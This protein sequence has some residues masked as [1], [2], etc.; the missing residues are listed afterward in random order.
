MT[1]LRSFVPPADVHVTPEHV[2]IVMDVPGFKPGEL[3]IELVDDLLTIRGERAFPHGDAGRREWYRFERGYGRFERS[4]RMPTGLDPDLV[5]ASLEDGVLNLLIPMPE[6]RK[7]R[8]I[9][10]VGGSTQPVIEQQAEDREPV[11]A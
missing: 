5:Q 9:E 1:L 11:T 7:P 8:K 2:S 4:L 3:D 10:V 6:S